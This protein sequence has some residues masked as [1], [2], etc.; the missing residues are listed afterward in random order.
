MLAAP[1]YTDLQSPMQSGSCAS[2]VTL[3]MRQVF[4]ATRQIV[5]FAFIN[6]VLSVVSY[7]TFI[8]PTLKGWMRRYLVHC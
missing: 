5:L 7:P 8:S 3:G 6:Q 1:V 2:P 4:P